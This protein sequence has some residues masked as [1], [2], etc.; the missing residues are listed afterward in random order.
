[1][2]LFPTKFIIRHQAKLLFLVVW[3]HV[4]ILDLC[5]VTYAG[6]IFFWQENLQLFTLFIH[7]I[8]ASLTLAFY[9]LLINISTRFR[10]NKTE[11]PLYSTKDSSY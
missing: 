7:L 3:G 11:K 6:P 8:V 1:M 9:F 4:T 10:I 5:Y 2:N